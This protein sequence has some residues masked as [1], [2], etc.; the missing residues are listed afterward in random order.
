MGLVINLVGYQ[1]QEEI[2]ESEHSVAYRGFR[3]CDQ[4][5]VIIKALKDEFPPPRE[6]R[7]YRNEYEIAGLLGDRPGIGRL[8]GL[9]S[10]HNTLV[11]IAEDWGAE[12]LKCLIGK[13]RFALQEVLEIGGKAAAA[14]GEIH[15]AHVVHKDINPANILYNQRTREVRLIDFGISTRLSRE[16][17]E[18]EGPEIIEGTLSYVS[19]EQTGRMNC[20]VDFRTDYYSLGATLYHLLVGRPPFLSEDPRKLL[21]CHLHELPRAPCLVNPDIPTPVS[22]IVMKLLSKSPET[23]YQ[24]TLGLKADLE[25][26]LG[27][28]GAEGRIAPFALG[29]RDVSEELLVPHKLYG[30]DREIAELLAGF[31]RIR[32]GGR[33]LMLV[34]GF[35][36]IGKTSLVREIYKPLTRDAGYFISG[37]SDPMQRNRPYGALLDAFRQLCR[38]LLAEPLHRLAAWKASL[39]LALGPNGQVLLEL[40]PE[41][42][43]ILGPQ[44]AAA[45]L[46][47]AE[48]QNRF[49]FVFERFVGVFAKSAHPLVLFLDDLQWSDGASLRLMR[50]LLGSSQI[51][52]LLVIAAFRD[53]EVDPHHPLQ[54]TLADIAADQMVLQRIALTALTLEQVNQLLGDALHSPLD[55]TRPLADLL[56]Q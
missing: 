23:R 49:N 10:V 53:N 17:L 42:E 50:H 27:A 20:P 4:T 32:A 33:E 39:L 34:S 8:L 1:L 38:Q 52:S 18:F 7:K 6:L 19:P 48:R 51:T 31:G 9:E 16:G 56:H 5:P 13:Q 2:Y 37:K 24:S 11:I 14:L 43:A 22:D 45:V 26:C 15:A 30:R 46:P 44:P 35:S 55:Q 21:R 12:S 54:S 28:L 41:Y 36:G 40:L 47:P 29:A 3:L 25:A